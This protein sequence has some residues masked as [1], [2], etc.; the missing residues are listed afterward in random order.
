MNLQITHDCEQLNISIEKEE[1]TEK[2]EKDD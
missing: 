2:E 1:E